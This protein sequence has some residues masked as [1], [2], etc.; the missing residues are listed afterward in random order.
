M[1]QPVLIQGAMA[2]E[3]EFFQK[4]LEKQQEVKIGPYSFFRGTF[5]NTPVVLSRLQIG[6]ATT[7]AV[8]A[9]AIEKFEPKFIVNQGTAGSYTENLCN[10]DIVIGERFYDAGAIFTGGGGDALTGVTLPWKYIDL[11]KIEA[12]ESLQSCIS[13]HPYY[14][15]SDKELLHLIMEAAVKYTKGRVVRGTVASAEQWNCSSDLLQQLH[16]V[17]GAD[18]EEMEV[19]AAGRVATDWHIPFICLKIISNNNVIGQSFDVQTAVALQEF[20]WGLF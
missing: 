10:Y 15:Y 7:A 19:A 18:C 4:K 16:N 17:T 13:L 3:L 6:F 8:T 14:Y 20:I 9:L 2:C 1:E 12:A 11:E 5:N